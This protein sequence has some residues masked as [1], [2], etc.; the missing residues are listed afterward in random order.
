[1]TKTMNS[2]LQSGLVILCCACAIWATAGSS[3][4]AAPP[5]SGRLGPHNGSNGRGFFGAGTGFGNWGPWSGEL[6]GLELNED[7]NRIPFYALHPPVYYSY[8]IARPY[9]DSP[10]ASPPGYYGP[11]AIV[12]GGPQTIINP[13][14]QPGN[15]APEAVPAPPT[16]AKPSPSNVKPTAGKTAS[17]VEGFTPSLEQLPTPELVSVVDTSPAASNVHVVLNPFVK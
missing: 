2:V 5:A 12:D 7:E 3:A 16:P 4:T 6:F 9:G 17:L 14:A 13:Y 8:P 15:A 1:M 10:F 11:G